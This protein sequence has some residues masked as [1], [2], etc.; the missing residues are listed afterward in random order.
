MKRCRRRT[1][2]RRQKNGLG[3][4]YTKAASIILA[5]PLLNLI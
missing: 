4:K 1:A 5:V 2:E 3:A